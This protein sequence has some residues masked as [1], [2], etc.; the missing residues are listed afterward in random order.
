MFTDEQKPEAVEGRSNDPPPSLDL[1]PGQR[2]GSPRSSHIAS[3]FPVL[4]ASIHH[5]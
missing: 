4:L 5:A 1:A 3:T 2:A